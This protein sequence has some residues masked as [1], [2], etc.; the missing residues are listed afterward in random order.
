MTH[1]EIW[2]AID[3]FAKER[4]LTCSGLAK[5]CGLDPTIFNKS[6][7][8]YKSGKPRWMSVESIAKVLT[9]TKSVPQDLFKFIDKT[10]D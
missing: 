8:F 4:K 5:F 6:K 9:A 10:A 7:R 1:D 3:M 2:H